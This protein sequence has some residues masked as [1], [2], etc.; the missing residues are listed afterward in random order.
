MPVRLP[1]IFD[2]RFVANSSM[3]PLRGRQGGSSTT[4]R[5]S[6]RETFLPIGSRPSRAT[7]E[8]SGLTLHSDSIIQHRF[9]NAISSV[10]TLI[11]GV[12]D[13]FS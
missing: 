9:A 5:L 6:R 12:A 11:G 3:T 2:R 1:A 8:K 4:L 7:L 13:M 10:A